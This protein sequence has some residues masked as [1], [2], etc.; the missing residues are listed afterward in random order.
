[1]HNEFKKI[2]SFGNKS[3]DTTAQY[4]VEYIAADNRDDIIG[5]ILQDEFTCSVSGTKYSFGAPAIEVQDLS[6]DFLELV[7][8]DHKDRLSDLPAVAI[9]KVSSGGCHED[10]PGR[11][12]VSCAVVEVEF[13]A[14]VMNVNVEGLT[15][16]YAVDWG[17][18]EITS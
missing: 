7:V 4:R 11:C 13:L 15:V 16:T 2:K 8:V 9:G 6:P 17:I 18:P 12:S 10:H 1:M 14:R 5:Q 3:R